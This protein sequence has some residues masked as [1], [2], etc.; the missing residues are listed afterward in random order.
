M[1]TRAMFR[2]NVLRHNIGMEDQV[3]SVE[4]GLN[5]VY[6][7][8]ATSEMRKFWEATP[9]GNFQMTITNPEAFKAFRL[10]KMYYIDFTEVEE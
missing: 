5:P 3:Y 7:S 2:C 4:V 6:S 1:V 9:N 8:E 10:G